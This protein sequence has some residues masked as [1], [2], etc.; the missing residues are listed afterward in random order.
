L[1]LC[2]HCAGSGLRDLLVVLRQATC[3]KNSREWTYRPDVVTEVYAD[4]ASWPAASPLQRRIVMTY[5]QAESA[6]QRG[7][8]I[9][10]TH[11]KSIAASIRA[12][13]WRG[14]N[15][16]KAPHHRRRSRL[17]H[18]W[19]E[20]CCLNRSDRDFR[21]KMQKLCWRLQIERRY[22]KRK[23]Y[24]VCKPGVWRTATTVLAR[25]QFYLA[26][27]ALMNFKKPRSRGMGQRARSFPRSLIPNSHSTAE[28]W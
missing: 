24:N 17:G 28:I 20:T 9:S 4:E 1:V 7:Q 22:T 13:S 25:L 10:R 5:E 18:H 12:C 8:P 26:S 16:V 15:V 14:R 11:S 27:R 2:A 3:R 21:R 6:L 23:L 19:L